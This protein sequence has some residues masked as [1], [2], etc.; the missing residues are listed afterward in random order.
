MNQPEI[1]TRLLILI[2]NLVMRKVY[3][4]QSYELFLTLDREAFK[5]DLFGNDFTEMLAK[6]EFKQDANLELLSKASF[7]IL[8]RIHFNEE[9]GEEYIYL[10]PKVSSF[11]PIF[12]TS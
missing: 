1:L 5:T 11:F 4:D 10:I 6:N 12:E 7:N 3:S 9:I 2:H 8:S